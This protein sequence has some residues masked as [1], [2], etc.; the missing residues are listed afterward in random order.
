MTTLLSEIHLRKMEESLLPHLNVIIT[1][2]IRYL[3]ADK[4]LLNY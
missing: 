4:H 2:A 1:M 3:F